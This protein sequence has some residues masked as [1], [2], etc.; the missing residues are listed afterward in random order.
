MSAPRTYSHAQM[1]LV[2]E[3]PTGHSSDDDGAGLPCNGRGY[4]PEGGDKCVCDN[5]LPQQGAYGY[6]GAECDMPIFGAVADG[7]DMTSGCKDSH[8]N[9]LQPEDWMCY[10]VPFASK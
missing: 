3:L 5:V 7:T 8:C 6:G 2:A 4:K 1:P 9:Y 10:S